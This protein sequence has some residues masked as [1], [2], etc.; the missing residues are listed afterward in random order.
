[1]LIRDE[2]YA[3]TTVWSMLAVGEYTKL[4]LSELE[5]V[6]RIG[7]ECFAN[8]LEK[9]M[10]EISLMEESSTQQRGAF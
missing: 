10:L 3:T 8:K 7:K 5:K 1:M 6:Y 2:L 9:L 4:T